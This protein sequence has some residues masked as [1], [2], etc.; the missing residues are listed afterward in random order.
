MCSF[1]LALLACT[2]TANVSGAL[3]DSLRGDGIGG[4]P[5]VCEGCPSPVTTAPDGT[6]ELASLEPGPYV[7]SASP[8]GYTTAQASFHIDD[9]GAG[10]DSVEIAVVPKPEHFGVFA[11]APDQLLE[12][13]QRDLDTDLWVGVLGYEGTQ[14]LTRDKIPLVVSNDDSL[15]LLV[16][17]TAALSTTTYELLTDLRPNK[18]DKQR[19]WRCHGTGSMKPKIK[20]VGNNLYLLEFADLP[21]D[22]YCLFSDE[23]NHGYLVNTIAPAPTETGPDK[24]G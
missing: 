13:A 9:E 16:Y 8:N 22:A 5:L 10:P 1:M 3:I 7:V 18:R 19:R 23:R 6:F 2:P 4:V 11:V 14:R 20:D 12:L 24:D 15:R 17:D 21:K